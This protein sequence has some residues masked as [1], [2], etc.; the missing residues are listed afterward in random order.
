MSKKI[1]LIF[2]GVTYFISHRLPIA[3]ELKRQGYEVHIVCPDAEPDDFKKY[4]FTYHQVK[5]SRKGMNPLSELLVIGKLFNLFKRIKPDLVHLVTIKPY[6]YGG[7]ASRLAGVPSVVYAVAG[8]GTV[9][10][11]NS[12]KYSLV[13]SFLYCLYKISFDHKNLTIVFQNKDDKNLLLSWLNVADN[14]AVLIR[15]SGVDLNAFVPLT[16]NVEQVPVVVL[17]ARLLKDKGVIE[18]VEAAHIIKSRGV[19]AEFWLV[20]EI[21]NGNPNTVSEQQLHKWEKQNLVVCKGYQNDIA[22]IFSQ[23]N[24]VVLPSYREGLPKVLIEAAACGRAV[25]TTDVP[26]CRDAITPNETGLLVPVKNSVA[27]ADAIQYLIEDKDT[28]L[29]M[30]KAGRKLAEEVFDINKVVEQHMNIYKRL[31][32]NK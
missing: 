29:Y 6:L 24:L 8:L 26:G 19:K 30:G 4:D 23:V 15:G 12:L 32:S 3:I 18:F 2:N 13:R 14:K 10:I 31:E 11:D 20:G 28:R 5:M 16:E 27:L 25:V 21:D 22:N 7:I 17:A 1:I 9:F